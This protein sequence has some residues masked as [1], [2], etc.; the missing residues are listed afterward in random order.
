MRTWQ[1][2]TKTSALHF[3]IHGRVRIRVDAEAPAR[4]RTRELLPAGCALRSMLHARLESRIVC[5]HNEGPH[6]A[7]VGAVGGWTA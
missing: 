2:K 6:P 1:T 5:L 3:D 4:H 7:N